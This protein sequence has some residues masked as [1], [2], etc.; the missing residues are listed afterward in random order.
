MSDPERKAIQVADDVLALTFY[1]QKVHWASPGQ[2]ATYCG[3]Q[4]NRYLGADTAAYIRET[5][6]TLGGTCA[7]CESIRSAKVGS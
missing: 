4:V 7:K 5:Y 2:E 6:G 1:G 3:A